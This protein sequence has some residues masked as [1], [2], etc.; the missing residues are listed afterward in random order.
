MFLRSTLENAL[1]QPGMFELR[2]DDGERRVMEFECRNDDNGFHASSRNEEDHASREQLIERICQELGDGTACID[3]DDGSTVSRIRLERGRIHRETLTSSVGQ[4]KTSRWAIGKSTHLDPERTAPLLKEIGLMTDEGEIKAPMRKKFKQVNHFLE[5]VSPLF[6]NEDEKARFTIV[7]CGC[8]KSYLGFV[9][10]WHLRRTL[11]RKGRFIGI[12]SSQ[13]NID[14]CRESAQR[15]K[16]DGME[17]QCSSI[18]DAELDDAVDLLASLHACDTATD[19]ALALGAAIKAR[20]IIAVPCC[21]HEFARRID[22]PPHYPI[23]RHGLFKQ[24]FADLLTDMCRSLFLEAQGYTVTVGEF[25]SVEDTPKNLMLK[26][27]LGNETAEERRGEYDAFKHAYKITP[28]IDS[29]FMERH[30][31]KQGSWSMTP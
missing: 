14:R 9:L 15:L 11:N 13:H 22:G 30:L 18:R 28:S 8:G 1:K 20:N 16:L 31:N 5:L 3:L 26:A 7:D 23:K 27:T 19:E 29:L 10:F 2:V 6:E 17:F 24:R 25:V 4:L 21:Q 12:D